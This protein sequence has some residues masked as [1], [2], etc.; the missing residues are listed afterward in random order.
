LS[1]KYVGLACSNGLY[2]DQRQVEAG[3]CANWSAGHK[4]LLNRSVEA[5]VF[6]TGSV[7]ILSEGLTYDRCQVAVVTNIDPAALLPEYYVETPEQLYGALRTVVD[8]VLPD[9]TA[10]LNARDPLVLQMAELCDGGV[11]LFSTE[12]RIA[13]IAEQRSQGKRAI[14]IRDDKIIL[15]TGKDETLLTDMA[16]I[17][18]ASN[19]QA[20]QAENVLAAT[21]AAWALGLSLELIRAGIETFGLDGADNLL[22]T[23]PEQPQA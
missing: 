1:G 4:I 3:N 23:K 20:F 5:A 2:L 10:V 15:A 22:A 13:A 12:E 14:F 21:G 19:G 11:I 7:S 17:P 18:L 6:E 9:G 16:A 8:V